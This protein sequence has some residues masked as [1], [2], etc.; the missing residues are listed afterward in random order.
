[1]THVA[2]TRSSGLLG[3]AGEWE[4]TPG[5]SSLGAYSG[6]ESKNAGEKDE[7]QECAGSMEQ[8]VRAH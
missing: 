8:L 4:P 1:M 7:T 2:P 5:R 6:S 3:R